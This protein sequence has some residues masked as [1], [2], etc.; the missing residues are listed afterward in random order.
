MPSPNIASV[1]LQN[2][3]IRSSFGASNMLGVASNAQESFRRREI[4]ANVE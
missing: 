2:T 4:Y 3:T 1:G